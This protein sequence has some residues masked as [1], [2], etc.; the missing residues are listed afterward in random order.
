MR[1]IPAKIETRVFMSK[2]KKRQV[3]KKE[4]IWIIAWLPVR[5]HSRSLYIPLPYEVV[6]LYN[7]RKGDLVKATLHCVRHAPGSEEPLRDP[8]ESED[9]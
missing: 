9:E 5:K 6:L 8:G 2:A 7:I 3:Q 4:K 1:K